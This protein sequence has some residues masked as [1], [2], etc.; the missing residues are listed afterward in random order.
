MTIERRGTWAATS[1]VR[2]GGLGI[3]LGLCALAAPAISRA[4]PDPKAPPPAT[5]SDTTTVTLGT[6]N[7]SL[8][9]GAN[10]SPAAALRSWFSYAVPT[11]VDGSSYVRY[12]PGAVDLPPPR[13]FPKGS[14]QA[15]P[16]HIANVGGIVSAPNEAHVNL[17][18]ALSGWTAPASS[19]VTVQVGGKS[20]TVAFGATEVMIP[21]VAMGVDALSITVN[22]F[23]T[24]NGVP[25]PLV[26]SGL[27]AVKVDSPTVGLVTPR[28]YVLTVVYAPPGTIGAARAP[29]ASST[30]TAAPLG[31][32]PP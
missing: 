32:Q 18:L 22:G 26:V 11:Y 3:V 20:Q 29:R 31:R 10:R 23:D 13:G 14:R 27:L 4:C 9:S 24:T 25:T 28:Y 8:A 12:V 5:A 21:D 17:C 15:V 6:L 1:R 7:L 2:S 19:S 30:P 16:V